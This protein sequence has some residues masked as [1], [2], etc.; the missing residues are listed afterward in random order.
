MNWDFVEAGLAFLAIVIIP[1]FI[2]ELAWS[3][4]VRA[5][6]HAS[7][8]GRVTF[9]DRL[10]AQSLPWIVFGLIGVVCALA[11]LAIVLVPR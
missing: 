10:K 9:G 2:L 3:R 8:S 5:K 11:A 7:D 4:R 6:I 1:R